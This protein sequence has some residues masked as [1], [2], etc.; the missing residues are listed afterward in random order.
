MAK[1]SL[2]DFFGKTCNI[3]LCRFW[4]E[5]Q[6]WSWFWNK[7]ATSATVLILDLI[8]PTPLPVTASSG[9]ACTHLCTEEIHC[10]W[11]FWVQFYLRGNIRRLE[12][13]YPWPSIPGQLSRAQAQPRKTVPGSHNTASICAGLHHFV[14]KQIHTLKIA[15]VFCLLIVREKTKKCITKPQD[16]TILETSF[17]RFTS[18]GFVFVS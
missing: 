8:P 12:L 15:I 3:C 18:S 2:R 1:H 7:T 11:P 16:D 14:L 6:K 5:I 13:Q 10:G 4:W 17:A 9:W